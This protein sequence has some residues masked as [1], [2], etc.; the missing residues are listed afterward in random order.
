VA[1]AH[2]VFHRS[3]F[4]L[5]S[6]ALAP[7]LG[8]AWSP[9]LKW[10]GWPWPPLVMAVGQFMLYRREAYERAGRAKWKDRLPTA[11]P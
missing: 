6:A 4:A 3:G 10:Q 8:H 5:A 2:F 11:A 1:L 7:I 9:F